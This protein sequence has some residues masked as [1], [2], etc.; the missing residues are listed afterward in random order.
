MGDHTRPPRRVLSTFVAIALAVAALTAVVPTSRAAPFPALPLAFD[1]KFLSNLS[2]PDMTPGGQSTLGFQVADPLTFGSMTNVTLSL[3]VYAF[4]AFP[5]NA[6]S[7]TASAGT[8]VLLGAS[9]SGTT[10]N[11]SLDTILPGTHFDGSVGVATASD[12]PAGTFAVRTA[13][14]FTAS[15]SHY[16]L[17]SRGWFTAS[18]WAAATE[19]PNGS[20]TLNLTTLGVSGVTAET[21][22]LVASS[23]WDWAL[24]LILGASIVLVGAGAFV[25]FRRG[26]KSSTGAR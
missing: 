15:G 23:D 7:S 12:T 18:L 10:V 3:D 14:S 16:R 20:V 4:N 11:V 13:L 22:I 9:S 26:P 1:S 24:V 21:A 5:G 2:G 8:P 19:L 25:Y 6:T 17:E